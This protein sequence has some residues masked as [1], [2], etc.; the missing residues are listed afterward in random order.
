MSIDKHL[1]NAFLMLGLSLLLV[2]CTGAIEDNASSPASSGGVEGGIEVR[3]AQAN[4]T[5]PT[6]TGSFWMEIM[7]HG[8]A[9]DAL[10][11]ASVDGCAVL[12]LH[13]MVME[14]DTMVMREVEGGQIP[15]PAGETVLLQKGGL[16]VMCIGKE[17]PLEIGTT[18]EIALQFANA[19]KITATATVVEPGDAPMGQQ[20]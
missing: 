11:G 3:N 16:H 9:D 20:Q 12:E 7:N 15:I 13:D 8:T 18:V 5:L 10:I 2:A 6:E 17:A 1:A 19:G 4:M 14:G